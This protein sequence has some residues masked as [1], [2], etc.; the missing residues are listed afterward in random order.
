M[1]KI[2]TE[3][4]TIIRRKNNINNLINIINTPSYQL[5]PGLANI[6]NT[7]F[8]NAAMQ[9]CIQYRMLQIV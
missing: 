8:H 3:I 4:N 7:C 5:S 1:E 2:L 6:G 9:L